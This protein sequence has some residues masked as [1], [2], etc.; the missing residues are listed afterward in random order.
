MAK[1]KTTNRNARNASA[2][3]PVARILKLRNR[4]AM[5]RRQH[6]RQHQ[7]AQNLATETLGYIETCDA[8]MLN[9][10]EEIA[11]TPAQS[12]DD[13]LIKLR[14]LAD[15]LNPVEAGSSF[16]PL[17]YFE[18]EYGTEYLSRAALRQLIKDA[19]KL[20]PS[21][22]VVMTF[23]EDEKPAATEAQA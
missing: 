8:I 4:Y 10:L 12:I 14:A 13:I 11:T 22:R 7:G 18:D 23:E 3:T 21:I 9:G 17:T 5:E 15:D 6:E 2:L 1:T 19:E 20:T 16:L